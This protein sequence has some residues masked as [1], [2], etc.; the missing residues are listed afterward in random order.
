MSAQPVEPDQV[1]DELLIA[2]YE[3]ARLLRR[4]VTA[5]D[6]SDMPG[7]AK[8]PNSGDAIRLN[9]QID[10]AKFILENSPALLT[11]LRAIGAYGT[12]T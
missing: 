1:V 3:A 10:A 6:D 8:V 2:N 5:S 4:V 11:H 12:N 9:R 7:I